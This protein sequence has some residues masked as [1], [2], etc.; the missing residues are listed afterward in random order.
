MEP[1]VMISVNAALYNRGSEA[2]IKGLILV[3]KKAYPRSVISLTSSE[4]NFEDIANIA[5][6]NQYI[7]KNIYIR[8]NS[9][10]RYSLAIMRRIPGFSKLSWKIRHKKV[11]DS[12]KNVD[13]IIVIGAD[14][15]DKSY[16][17]LNSLHMLN[18]LFK[19][20][21][22]AKLLL[23]D[24]SLEEK[25]IDKEVINDINMFDAVT[26]RE[27]ITL[28]N[29]LKY[30]NTNKVF[31]F[32]D[33]AFVLNPET[34]KLPDNWEDNNMI[35]IN[36]SNLIVSEK[37]GSNKQI[38]LSSYF[39]L[40]NYI[41]HNTKLK[42]VLVPHVMNGADLQMLKLIYDKYKETGKVLLIEDESL[43]SNQLK[44]IISKCRFFIGARTHA[45]IAAYSSCVPTLVLGYSIKSRGIAK[46]LFGSEKNYV[47]PVNSLKSQQELVEGFKWLQ[48][49]ED[50]IRNHLVKIIP[51]YQSKTWDICSLL[52]DMLEVN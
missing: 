40:I 1:K 49:N 19:T 36:L 37:Y 46:D 7:N 45:T 15:Y 47:I 9:L 18:E 24:C 28:N 22:K 35:G 8:D 13:L 6:V 25:H 12:A 34:C 32:P 21:T 3:I 5:D 33:P 50:N 44:F 11:L 41:I 20:Q 43:N 27:S 48:K 16:N 29:F 10:T 23:F 4:E 31:Y 2:L 38:I 42:I 52:K 14:N 30:I 39:E 51:E 17:M 26:V